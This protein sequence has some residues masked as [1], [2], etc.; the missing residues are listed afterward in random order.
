MQWQ[1]IPETTMIAINGHE[2]YVSSY[3]LTVFRVSVIQS[4]PGV[5]SSTVTVKINKYHLEFE[6]NVDC[7]FQP[8]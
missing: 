3:Y 7:S 1:L 8:S 6:K 2:V 4:H 5:G